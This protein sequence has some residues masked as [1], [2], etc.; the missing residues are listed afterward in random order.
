LGVNID[1]LARKAASIAVDSEPWRCAAQGAVRSAHAR[2]LLGLARRAGADVKA[3]RPGR[4]MI[5]R[6]GDRLA[7]LH[8]QR[9]PASAEINFANTVRA[10]PQSALCERRRVLACA[11]PDTSPRWALGM[12][13]S[14]NV[15]FRRAGGEPLYSATRIS[16]PSGAV[17]SARDGQFLLDT[18]CLQDRFGIG[19]ALVSGLL[20]PLARLGV[21]LRNA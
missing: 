12:T 21:V 2:S 16:C 1:A 15:G 11:T 4:R 9:A 6:S 13:P 17:T 5:P 20:V 18:A 10:V 14:R 8:G 19:V 7:V 3:T